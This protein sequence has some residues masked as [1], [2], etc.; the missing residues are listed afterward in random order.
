MGL[1]SKI[2]NSFVK[3]EVA[4]TPTPDSDTKKGATKA[5]AEKPA[6]ASVKSE[7]KKA[8]KAEKKTAN[9]WQNVRPEVLSIL[10]QPDVT[11]KATGRIADNQ[12]VFLVKRSATK[13]QIAEAVHTLYK[14]DVTGVRVL[15]RRGKLIR[16]V[17]GYGQRKAVKKAYVSVKN[18]QSIQLFDQAEAA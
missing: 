1:F 17:R 6:A 12:Y 8:V 11:E 15:N 9:V 16:T 5:K 10:I 3:S 2:K 14:V 7:S 4:K 18:G 13:P